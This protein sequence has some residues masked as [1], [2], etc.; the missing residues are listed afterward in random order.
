MDKPGF[1]SLFYEHRIQPQDAHTHYSSFSV[2]IYSLSRS[3]RLIRVKIT[4]V[5][6]GHTQRSVTAR[7]W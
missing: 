5:K 3:S 1:K 2:S 4:A 6:K 7:Q